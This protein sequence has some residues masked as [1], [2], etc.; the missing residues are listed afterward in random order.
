MSK[1]GISAKWGIGIVGIMILVVS[2]LINGSFFIINNPISHVSDRNNDLP[3]GT[4]QRDDNNSGMDKVS[5]NIALSDSGKGSGQGSGQG[6]GGGIN[7]GNTQ[8]S[9]Q[10]LNLK[11]DQG[12]EQEELSRNVISVPEFPTVA[13]PIVSII[14]I[15]YLFNRRKG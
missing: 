5:G 7:R 10:A 9:G 4:N 8:G 1:S 11:S 15:T 2:L 13:L 14:T 3:D 12:N 6:S